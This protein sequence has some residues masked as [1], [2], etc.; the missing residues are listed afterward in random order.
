MNRLW[1]DKRSQKAGLF[2]RWLANGGEAVNN[3]YKDCE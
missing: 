2:E 3:P 1:T